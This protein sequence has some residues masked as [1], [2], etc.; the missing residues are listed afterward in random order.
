MINVIK[1]NL[2][3]MIKQN[4]NI[5]AVAHGCNCFNKM[6]AGFALQLVRV[7]PEV[8]GADIT[9]TPGDMKKLG[10]Y[11][12]CEVNGRHYYNLYTQYYYGRQDS[13]F[14]LMAFRTA[15]MVA[16][17]EMMILGIRSVHIPRIGSGLGQGDWDA[18]LVAI[19]QIDNSICKDQFVI[20]IVEL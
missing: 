7:V 15:F 17:Q 3:T 5:E 13:H 19:Q 1:G 10:T 14:D 12:R 6:G 9:T 11:S 16:I 18:I 2:I 20:N 4:N 8:L